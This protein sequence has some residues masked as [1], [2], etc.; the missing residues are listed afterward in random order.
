MNIWNVP[1]VDLKGEGWSLS[2]YS[3]NV[4]LICN[5]ASQCGFT[6][7]YKGLQT[8]H[9][10][11][12]DQGFS[13]LAFPCNQFGAQEPLDS[14]QNLTFCESNFGVSFR[15]NQRIEVN[16]ES[17]HQVFEWLKAEAPG[18]LGNQ[19]IKWNFTKFLVNR[20]G[21]VLERFAPITD[22]LQL[23][24]KIKNLLLENDTSN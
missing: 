15:V 12:S 14:E 8:L 11:Y 24:K 22:P 7:Q 17:T 5:T 23:E 19:A 3:G 10:R 2:E 16:G 6:K 21:Q 9:E 20:K 1:L 4:L 13:V 18:I